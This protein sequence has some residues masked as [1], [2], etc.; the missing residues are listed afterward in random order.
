M[1]SAVYSLFSGGFS[2]GSIVL[3]GVTPHIL[4]EASLPILFNVVPV[5]D[6]PVG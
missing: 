5:V 3:F 1:I 2:G 4:E 6:D